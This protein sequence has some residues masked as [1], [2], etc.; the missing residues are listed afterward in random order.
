M[1]MVEEGISTENEQWTTDKLPVVE[2]HNEWIVKCNASNRVDEL[3]N[4][5]QDILLVL[6]ESDSRLKPFDPVSPER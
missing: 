5:T 3:N 2:Q 4:K 6:V 1:W